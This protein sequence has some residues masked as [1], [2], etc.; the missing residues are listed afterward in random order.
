MKKRI[1]GY[2]NYAVTDDGR[3][4]N[5]KTNRLLRVDISNRG[6]HRITVCKNNKPKKMT[7]HR[8]V[9]E[10]FIPNPNNYQTVNHISGDKSDNSIN[11]LEWMSQAQ[12]Q[13][14]AVATGLCPRGSSNG[15]SKYSE[16]FIDVVCEL[17]SQGKPRGEVIKLTGIT[18][19][20]FDDVRRRKTWAH[21]SAN[22]VW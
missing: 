3:V 15:N 5:C 21:I 18:K 6:Y 1:V 19:S 17:I 2:E 16:N 20:A 8:L 7:I 22:Y 13:E 11:N 12:N 4:F 10:L 14:H 9:A